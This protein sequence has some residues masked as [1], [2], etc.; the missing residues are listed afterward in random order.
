MQLCSLRPSIPLYRSFRLLGPEGTIACREYF[1]KIR[2]CYYENTLYILLHTWSK[3]SGTTHIDVPRGP[4]LR[5][6]TQY[7]QR[8]YGTVPL[9]VAGQEEMNDR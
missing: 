4:K 5:E 1:V 3:L 6:G 8:N 7:G 2:V 9:V